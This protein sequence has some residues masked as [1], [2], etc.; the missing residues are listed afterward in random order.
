MR[1]RVTR[2][3]GV[4]NYYV[5]Y[6]KAL[7]AFAYADFKFTDALDTIRNWGF[8]V[9]DREFEV[10]QIKKEEEKILE[11]ADR[12]EGALVTR[13]E[14]VATRVID[15]NLTKFIRHKPGMVTTFCTY[16]VTLS[17]GHPDTVVAYPITD[18]D[19]DT[20]GKML[21]NHML[22]ICSI[23]LLCIHHVC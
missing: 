19:G 16:E 9:R 17:D 8:Y 18:W 11:E 15:R 1:A 10:R 7:K 13:G 3:I 2:I 20:S 4:T 22:G 6:M 23:V 21:L 12:G 5:P 14:E